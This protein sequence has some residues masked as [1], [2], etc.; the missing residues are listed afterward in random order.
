MQINRQGCTRIVILTKKWAIKIPNFYEYR[1]M[2]CGILANLQEKLFSDVGYPE[3]CP[4][5]FSLPF[6]L[7]VVMPKV[8][9]LT[10]EEFLKLDIDSFIETENYIIPTEKKSNSFGLLN[11]KL[12]VIDYGGFRL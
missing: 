7:C 3:L 12:V 10:D 5:K 8:K 11:G 9:V 4:V 1:L 2:L 6:G